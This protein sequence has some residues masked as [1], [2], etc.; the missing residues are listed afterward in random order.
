MLPQHGLM[1]STMST[2]RIRTSETLGCRSGAH[3]LNHLGTRPVSCFNHSSSWLSCHIVSLML[4]NKKGADSGGSFHSKWWMIFW[5]PIRES[6]PFDSGAT[7]KNSIW[8]WAQQLEAL[9]IN[10]FLG[11]KVIWASQCNILAVCLEMHYRELSQKT[12]QVEKRALGGS[13][14]ASC[15]FYLSS[16]HDATSWVILYHLASLNFPSK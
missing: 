5:R 10:I 1:S 6:L 3:K 13:S 4:G 8:W 14:N 15:I 12:P 16:F 9:Q 7:E 11:L 2:P